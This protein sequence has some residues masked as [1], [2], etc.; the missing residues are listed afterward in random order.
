MISVTNAA[1]QKLLEGVGNFQETVN[2]VLADETELNLTN[3]DLWEG[4]VA[5]DYSIANAGKFQVGTAAIGACTITLYNFDDAFTEYDF[6]DATVNVQLGI[7]LGD[8]TF[9]TIQKG[10][11]T[12]N[13]PGDNG[14]RIVLKCYDNMH[15]FDR[16]Y[17]EVTTEY[18]C[19]ALKAVQD[20]CDFCNVNLLSTSFVGAN[21]ILPERPDSDALTC[22]QVLAY[23]A[24][25]I[26]ANAS[27]DGRGR[28]RF[29]WPD[30]SVIGDITEDLDG[31]VFDSAN[32]YN[33]G[34]NADGGIF[35]PW[36]TSN[37]FYGGTFHEGSGSEVLEYSSFYSF[38]KQTENVTITGLQVTAYGTAEGETE[39]RSVLAGVEG[40]LLNIEN[41]PFI[42]S[43]NIEEATAYISSKV[44]GISFRPLNFRTLSDPTIE[45]GDVLKATDRKGNVYYSI[46]TTVN[47][48]VGRGT[49]IAGEAEPKLRN[50]AKR[51]TETQQL[52]ETIQ[53]TEEKLTIKLS[54]YELAQQTLAQMQANALGYHTTE[55]TLPDGS[56]ITYQHDKPTLA[57]STIIYKRTLEAF[58]VSTDGGQTWNAGFDAQGNAVLN[59]L[60][61]IGINADWIRSGR[62]EVVDENDNPLFYADKD[63]GEVFMSADCIKLSASDTQ[64][65][66]DSLR[67]DVNSQISETNDSVASNS[68]SIE[69]IIAREAELQVTVDG[70]QSDVS[71]ISTLE[72]QIQEVSSSVTQSADA[73]RAEFSETVD[74]VAQ[75]STYVQADTNG[76][77][78]GKVGDAS[79]VTI[80]NNRISFENDGS[81]VAYIAEQKMHIANLEVEERLDLGNFAFVPRANGNLSFLKVR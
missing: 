41:N 13:D 58:T 7:P 60:N 40:Y 46:C 77:H 16:D 81:E 6:A 15:K 5:Y 68:S 10:F 55:E 57:E 48:K 50:S 22:R 8:G 4:G 21:I 64:N 35:D 51:Y 66:F 32:P 20:I 59:I 80:Q 43:E 3:S 69:Q 62:L 11:Y 45:P 74:G 31:G 37:D 49:T 79:R 25:R 67:D 38:E 14:T 12:V 56:T 36:E 71:R 72:N 19:T 76:L 75:I 34:D 61:A 17:S 23:I 42:T 28:L 30:M 70:I 2:I 29:G 1:R 18:P 65:A 24:Q 47:F 78:V 27:V 63:T 33:S 54:R 44:V 39:R 26:C 53:K 73:L 9:E 52:T